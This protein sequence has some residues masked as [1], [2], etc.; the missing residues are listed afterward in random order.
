MTKIF[1]YMSRLVSSSST[2]GWQMSVWCGLMSIWINECWYQNSYIIF[3][4]VYRS[5]SNM[6]ACNLHAVMEI[7]TEIGVYAHEYA[8]FFCFFI[9]AICMNLAADCHMLAG[10]KNMYLERDTEQMETK[11]TFIFVFFFLFCLKQ[12]HGMCWWPIQT[13]RHKH[14]LNMNVSLLIIKP[15]LKSSDSFSGL[16]RCGRSRFNWQLPPVPA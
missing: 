1:L 3:H 13:K 9:C 4:S 5:S 16:C 14:K 15:S 11:K 10:F 2:D 7:C 12:G 6:T 8:T